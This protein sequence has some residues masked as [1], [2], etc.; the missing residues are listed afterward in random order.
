MSAVPLLIGRRPVRRAHS[1]HPLCVSNYYTIY[2]YNARSSQMSSL[3]ATVLHASL[4][5]AHWR[6]IL[7]S[8]KA[9]A[10]RSALK[11][12]KGGFSAASMSQKPMR[13]RCWNASTRIGFCFKR[14]AWLGFSL[15]KNQRIFRRFSHSRAF[16]VSAVF[17]QRENATDAHDPDPGH[18]RRIMPRLSEGGGAQREAA[19]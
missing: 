19:Q 9:A 18:P 4:L 2:R 3:F 7:K 11:S 6:N 14:A 12:S 1:G 10:T 8:L 13:C 17:G 16:L 15:S 5:I